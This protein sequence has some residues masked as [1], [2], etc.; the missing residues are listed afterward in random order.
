MLSHLISVKIF[1]LL[2]EIDQDN[3]NGLLLLTYFRLFLQTGNV[4]SI[5]GFFRNF[6]VY[7]AT[8]SHYLTASKDTETFVLKLQMNELKWGTNHIHST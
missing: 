2:I 3:L 6:S 8:R 1:F 4:N 7:C 5:K